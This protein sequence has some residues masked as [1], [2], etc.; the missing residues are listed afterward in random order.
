MGIYPEKMKTVIQK[1]TCNPVFTATL[2]KKAKKWKQPKCPSTEEWIKK[3]MVYT[4]T[5]THTH[6][7]EYYSAIK[8]QWNNVICSNMYGARDYHTK[9]HKSKTNLYD[10][11]YMWNLKVS[12]NESI[13]KIETDSQ[14]ENKLKVSKGESGRRDR[15]GVWD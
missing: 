14:T 13:Y 15:L 7:M 10:I 4:H 5:H 8:K 9:W 12:A 11:T 6:T 3:D 1:D 2:F